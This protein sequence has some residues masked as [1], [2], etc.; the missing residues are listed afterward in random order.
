[1]RH[2]KALAWEA[3]LKTVFDR[4]DAELEAK[5]GG[6]CPL[7]P[8]RAPSGQTTNPEHSGL[9]NVGA[10]FTPGYGSPTGPG[11]VVQMQ[12]ATLSRI[13][14]EVLEQIEGDSLEFLRRELPAAFPGKDLRVEREGHS[15]KIYG[16]LSLGT[17]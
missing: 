4:L 7:Y 1:M 6:T 16:D 13:P 8:S 11:Y 10:V 15:F 5:Y 17:V 12:M 9:F 3:Q 2:P 14:K